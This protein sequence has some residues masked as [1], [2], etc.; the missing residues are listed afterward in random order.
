MK[1][2]EKIA[3]ALFLNL[4][5]VIAEAIILTKNLLTDGPAIFAY[6]TESANAIALVSS[7]VFCLFAIRFLLK[8][9]GSIP[10]AVHLLR[11]VSTSMLLLVVFVVA[12][13]LSPRLGG[14]YGARM[15]FFSGTMFYHHLACPALAA[16]SFL[17]FERGTPLGRRH[18]ATALIPTALYAAI[19]VT[20]NALLVFSGP[21]PFFQIYDVPLFFSLGASALIF[22]AAL[23][24]AR[25]LSGRPKKEERQSF[26]CLPQLRL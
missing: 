23:L 26:D 15:L 14:L 5:V 2:K 25:L 13:V 8:G 18:V 12:F 7:L 11:Y 1:A 24:T 9:G 4:L 16:A 22:A 6:Y 20:L 10:A 19:L 3:Y 21:Y 17:L